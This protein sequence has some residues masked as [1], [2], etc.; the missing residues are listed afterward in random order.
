MW[1]GLLRSILPLTVITLT[2]P[3]IVK[4]DMF[5]CCGKMLLVFRGSLAPSYFRAAC[6]SK[7]GIREGCGWSVLG[8]ASPQCRG[9]RPTVQYHTDGAETRTGD[10]AMSGTAAARIDLTD[11]TEVE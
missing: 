5:C 1:M 2:K 3:L 8:H 9:F 7:L 10:R 4:P 11:H 6:I